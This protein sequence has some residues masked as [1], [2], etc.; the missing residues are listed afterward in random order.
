MSS[1][2]TVLG[3]QKA[4]DDVIINIIVIDVKPLLKK[5]VLLTTSSTCCSRTRLECSSAQLSELDCVALCALV[6]AETK[7]KLEE[8]V[9]REREEG[10]KRPH[11]GG[12][13]GVRR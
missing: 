5:I 6:G 11:T 13:S 9:E 10:M 12:S 2:I 3:A 8:Q 7:S 4:T 1:M